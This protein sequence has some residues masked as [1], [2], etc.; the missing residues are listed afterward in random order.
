MKAAVYKIFAE[1]FYDKYGHL[2]AKDDKN[3]IFFYNGRVWNNDSELFAGKVDNILSRDFHYHIEEWFLQTDYNNRGASLDEVRKYNRNTFAHLKRL[4]REI[5]SHDLLQRNVPFD[6]TSNKLC[7]RNGVMD[8][9]RN[10]FCPFKREDY[11]SMFVDY[12][13]IQP[14]LED[15]NRIEIFFEQVFVDEEDRKLMGKILYSCI[16]GIKF[17]KLVIATGTSP[18]GKSTVFDYMMNS[19]LT[20][21]FSVA[22]DTRL[23]R[24]R[25]LPHGTCQE[26]FEVNKKRLVLFSYTDKIR[27][28]VAN[29]LTGP[30][31]FYARAM[32]AKGKTLISVMG[33]VVD[34]CEEMPK[35][36]ADLRYVEIKFRSY[37]GVPR[38]TEKYAK[39]YIFERNHEYNRG[40][41]WA[42]YRCAVIEYL[43]RYSR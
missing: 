15:V 27:A 35:L 11:I 2:I 42:R 6:S 38:P 36:D 7:F 25:I 13:W 30:E 18:G 26:L 32:Y 1:I 20:N 23:L 40:E 4:Y 39:E 17:D 12:E 28:A 5:V 9:E 22:G 29:E 41:F 43:K 14:S 16:A 19:V 33:A 10:E 21:R 8:F 3:V 31:P 34:I 24:K 37:F